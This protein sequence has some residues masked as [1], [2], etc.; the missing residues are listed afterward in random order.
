MTSPPPLVIEAVVHKLE[1]PAL[2]AAS[3][4]LEVSLSAATGGAFPIA[5]SF[6]ESLSSIAPRAGRA[7]VVTSLLLEIA[8]KDELLRQTEARWRDQLMSL[9]EPSAASAFICTIFRHVADRENSATTE[10]IRRLNLMAVQLSHDTGAG[11]IDIDRI[12][13]Y[14]GARLLQ[15]DYRLGGAIAAELA[16]H[17]IVSEILSGGLDGFLSPSIQERAK[18]VQVGML[19]RLSLEVSW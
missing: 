19:Q 5:L 11:I 16:G 17:T 2:V 7:V 6:G 12:F 13:A 10:R 3:R 4:Q 9:P 18:K 14:F 1:R 8:S 15:T